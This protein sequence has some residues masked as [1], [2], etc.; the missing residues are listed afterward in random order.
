MIFKMDQFETRDAVWTLGFEIIVEES[1]VP[2]R[3]TL[4]RGKTVFENSFMSIDIYAS[5][6]ISRKCLTLKEN[7]NKPKICFNFGT[8][9]QREVWRGVT[10]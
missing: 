4:Y 3:E 8:I 2:S 1:Q 5:I 6:N 9:W 7:S 10:I